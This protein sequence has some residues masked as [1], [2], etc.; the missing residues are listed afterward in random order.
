MG[1]KAFGKVNTYTVSS[2]GSY[3]WVGADGWGYQ[4]EFNRAGKPNL[5]IP[6]LG[7]GSSFMCLIGKTGA[8]GNPFKVGSNFT[9][10]ADTNGVLYLGINDSI[11]DPD[12]N[13]ITSD[14][15]QYWRENAGSFNVKITRKK[16]ND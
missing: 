13:P 9:F 7:K 14:D 6:V 4:P 11:Q 2:D 3:K 10:T 12:G 16:A 5:Y 15:N 1:I 8:T